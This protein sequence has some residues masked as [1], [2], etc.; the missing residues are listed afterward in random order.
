MT[1]EGYPIPVEEKDRR[2]GRNPL[3][4][5]LGF[6]LLGLAAALILFGGNLFGRGGGTVLDQAGQLANAQDAPAISQI[7]ADPGAIIGLE[8]GQA[9]PEF[10]LPD[11]AGN[12]ISLGDFRGRPVIVNFWATWCAPCRIE[13]P[14][15]EAAQERYQEQG[16]AILALNREES[17]D[18]VADYFA[19]LG[20]TFTPLLDQSA[21]V[22][23][24]YN[25][26][27]M[28]TTYFIDGAGVVTVVH[29]GP[30]TQGQI[31]GYMATTLGLDG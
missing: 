17:R 10:T 26:F 27:N 28:P 4:L 1:D 30:M 2:S 31:D 15:L 19:E 29:R 16:L 23:D 5:L 9:A 7:P 22:A 11:L 14:E 24:Q 25:V 13:M 6:G 18:Q 20:L 21:L 3:I 12:P 8:V